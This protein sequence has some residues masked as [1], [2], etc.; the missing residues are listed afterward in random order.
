MTT[1]PISPAP[2][3]EPTEVTPVAVVT[4][5]TPAPTK[6]ARSGPPGQA[7][8][9]R[10]TAK[11]AAVNAPKAE[12]APAPAPEPAPE[13]APTPKAEP[14]VVPEI[15]PE[16][17]D[18]EPTIEDLGLP[19]DQPETPEPESEDPETQTPDGR[20]FKTLRTELK[21]EKAARLALETRARELEQRIQE[22]EAESPDVA[23]LEAKIKEYEQT[24][25][26]TRLEAS[27]A[28]KEA[29]ETPYR[30]VVA[31]ADELAERYEIDKTELTDAIAIPD[32]KERAAKLRDLLVGVED[33]DKLE[34]LDLGRE[35][36]KISARHQELIQNADKALAELEAQQTAAQKAELA[37]RTRER[38][39][40]V[41]KLIPHMASRLP[42]FREDIEKLQGQLA[43]TDFSAL[44]ATRQAYN[45]ATG[46]LLPVV[47]R[48]WNQTQRDL[49]AA[50]DELKA[51]RDASP[52]AGAGV[53]PAAKTPGSDGLGRT[54]QERI[55]NR[56]AGRA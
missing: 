24:L 40:A 25:S 48:R 38:R 34:I 1:E 15:E 2:A 43:D 51:Y 37:E 20:A 55:A 53:T 16:L 33:M 9:D 13:P 27:P 54:F 31:K 19:I 7:M 36:E 23:A 45:A 32:R 10:I 8:V 35:V 52:G 56:L 30:Q 18:V 42:S 11:M 12:P 29:I 5:P 17:A 4:E 14:T 3:A 28:Y 46:E 22:R 6:P 47:L 39:D 21:A 50:L 44:P 41:E 49:E 26:V